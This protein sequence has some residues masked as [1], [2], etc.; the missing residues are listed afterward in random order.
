MN[1]G[2]PRTALHVKGANWARIENV[3]SVTSRCCLDSEGCSNEPFVL[4]R[5]LVGT[6]VVRSVHLG[7]KSAATRIAVKMEDRHRSEINT[8]RD[9]GHYGTRR[10]V[11]GLIGFGQMLSA[12]GRR[13]KGTRTA[14]VRSRSGQQGRDD[15]PSDP[16]PDGPAPNLKAWGRDR[17]DL[18]GQPGVRCRPSRATSANAR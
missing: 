7:P 3:F 2:L 1:C 17:R 6:P 11:T 8:L 16:A 9:A 18:K 14:L 10:R 5:P 15:R 13:R 4:S 12:V